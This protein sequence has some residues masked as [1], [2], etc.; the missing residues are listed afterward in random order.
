MM[1]EL[2]PHRRG[3]SLNVLAREFYAV[4]ARSEEICA[5]LETEDHVV[6]PAPFVSPPKWHLAHTTWFFARFVLEQEGDVGL[7]EA[8]LL[9]NSY[10]KSQG[11]HWRQD[12]RG[13]LA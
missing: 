4:R 5:R 9:F 7:P 2:R 11:S 1:P 8:D 13:A 10:Y 6:Q 12:A 3:D